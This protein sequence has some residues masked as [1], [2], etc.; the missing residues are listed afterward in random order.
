MI[1]QFSSLSGIACALAAT[2]CCSA[3]LAND[4]SP[5]SWT[6]SG[7]G[8]LSAVH[9]NTDQADFTSSVL[10]GRGA[11]ASGRWSAD[12]DS[13]LGLQLNMALAPEWSAVLQLVSEQRYDNS[14][15]PQVEWA[16]VKY[17][18]TPDLAVRVGRVSLPV[19]MAAEH[20]KVGYIY[21]AVRQPNEVAGGLPIT[22]GDGADLS[23]RWHTGDVRHTTRIQAGRTDLPLTEGVRARA[24]GIAG[25]A[26]SVDVGS[27]SARGAVIGG[28]VTVNL[29]DPLFA[30][31]SQYGRAGVNLAE[32][33]SVDHK[34]FVLVAL[35]M[36]YDTGDW[37]ATIEGTRQRSQSLLGTN[38]AL[39]VG[40]GYRWRTF[41]PY[42]GYSTVH[43]QSDTTTSGLALA[44]LG[45][46]LAASGA[47]LNAALNQIL[48]TL[49][50]QSTASVGMRWDALENIALKLQC[51]RVT[52]HGTSRGTLKNTQPGF[53]SGRPINVTSITLDFVF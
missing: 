37:F 34:R 44:G 5:G 38:V 4:V 36:E 6:L 50:E 40:A 19:F 22:S 20:R 18:V 39:A 26:H 28:N 27:F 29:A 43:A 41:T 16:S 8:T 52:P 14:Y 17:Q 1:F 46:Q 33:Y 9:A 45:P 31:L 53:V 3:A 32:R 24:S 30:A 48:I 25:L 2:L 11:G 35:G 21:S 15:R 47:A 49:P 7:F 10:K 51:E 42:A 12:V 23:W 13:R